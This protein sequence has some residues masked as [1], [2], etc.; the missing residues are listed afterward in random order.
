VPSRNLPIR[1]VGRQLA[2]HAPF[3][4][5]GTA[6]GIAL[7]LLLTLLRVPAAVS[8]AAFWIL[9]PAH[10][11]LSAYVT[12]VMYRSAGRR[13]WWLLL[14]V[15]WAGSVGIA[16]LSDSVI[17]FLGELLLALPSRHIHV[18]FV[19]KWW[20]VNPL[21]LAGVALAHVGKSTRFPHA[22]HVLLSTWASLFHVTMAAWSPLR[23][24]EYLAVAAFLFLAVWV[25]CCTSD[26]VFPLL[27]AGPLAPPR[28]AK[29][30]R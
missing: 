17:P 2:A 26:I 23:A 11:L 15:G 27:L 7:V 5:V 28:G 8:E 24:V 22:A 19:E 6:S 13:T 1:E 18:G 3:T 29:T 21:A 16:T 25:P 14:L 9:H 10:V 12:T 4:A 20:L 30:R